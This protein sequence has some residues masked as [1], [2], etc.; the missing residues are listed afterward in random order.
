RAIDAPS[1]HPAPAPPR[2]AARIRTSAASSMAM[3]SAFDR[4]SPTRWVGPR[5]TPAA[6]ITRTQPRRPATANHR[7]NPATATAMSGTRTSDSTRVRRSWDNPVTDPS[8][9]D[10][11][12]YPGRAATDPEPSPWDM[13]YRVRHT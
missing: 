12:G 3:F 11:T 8:S 2:A 5:I 6:A 9:A 13:R 10:R 4:F 7:A 1:D